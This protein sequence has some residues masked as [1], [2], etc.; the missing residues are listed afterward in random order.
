M[1]S[2]KENYLQK[3]IAECNQ[4][5]NSKSNIYLYSK[6]TSNYEYNINITYQ[7]ELFPKSENNRQINQDLSFVLNLPRNYPINP[8]KLF[9]LTSLSYISIEICDAKDILEDVLEGKWNNKIRAKDIITAVPLFIQRCL[10]NKINRMF[11]G[12]YVLDSEYDYNML[13]KVPNFYFESCEQVIN[14]KNETVE[15]RLLMITNLFFLVF[16]YTSGIF[17]YS[18]IKL[19]FWA[20][21][22]S[23]Y[24][25]KHKNENFE[26][27]FG[28]TNSQREFMLIITKDGSKIMTL[29]LSI[30]NSRGIDYLVNPTKTNDENES[31][32]LP[33]IEE[34]NKVENKIENN[35]LNENKN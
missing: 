14:K 10:Q 33:K 7:K 12:K 4:I 19:V 32:K 11:I 30:L 6:Q 13:C 16:S 25:M 29:V 23:I 17:S 18:N 31:N 20:S 15:N 22:K 1:K 28:K 24:G 2:L 34:E 9:C 21:I 8:P 35:E 3:V 5:N 26:F 27:E